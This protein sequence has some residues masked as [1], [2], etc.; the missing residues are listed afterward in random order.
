MPRKKDLS[1]Q[2]FGRWKVLYESPI[3]KNG[4]V[5][6]HCQCQCDLKTEKDIIGTDLTFGKSQSC[7]CLQKE[8][9]AEKNS[10]NLIGQRFGKLIVIEKTTKRQDAMI[11]WKCQCDCGNITYVPTSY[12]TA[13]D[14]KSCGCL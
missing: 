10:L 5:V 14:T 1:G 7:G 2:T 8:R 13:G 3:R 4:K 11:V 9:A 12:L 6:W